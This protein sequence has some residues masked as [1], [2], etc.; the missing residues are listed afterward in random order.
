MRNIFARSITI[1]RRAAL[2]IFLIVM[3][4]LSVA[5]LGPYSVHA[6]TKPQIAAGGFHTVALNSD[7]TITA[8][9]YNGYGQTTVPA[10]LNGVTAIAAGIAHT[11]ALKSDGTVTA[12][13]E[14]TYGQTTVPGDLS[15]VTAIAV[16]EFHT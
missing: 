3:T 15:G 14:N 11:V 8:W 4:F 16:G 1:D 5:A 6:A 2:N 9:G 13:G 10:G 12:W 7:G